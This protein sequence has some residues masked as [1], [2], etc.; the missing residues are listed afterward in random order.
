M[1]PSV[2]E[3]MSTEHEA[4]RP[5]LLSMFATLK[6]LF[7]HC[8]QYGRADLASEVVDALEMCKEDF[9]A[10][11]EQLRSSEAMGECQPPL[12][13]M[14]TSPFAGRA[15]WDAGCGSRAPAASAPLSALG[16]SPHA[17]SAASAAEAEAADADID[18]ELGNAC[19][20]RSSDGARD[21]MLG[22]PDAVRLSSLAP[23]ARASIDASRSAA[24]VAEGGARGG[25]LDRLSSLSVTVA[26]SSPEAAEPSPPPQ[27]VDSP[28]A[29]AAML[30]QL[31]RLDLELL[32]EAAAYFDTPQVGQHTPPAARPR[33]PPLAAWDEP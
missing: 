3:A 11:A 23:H 20:D 28:H 16:R 22:S 33:F 15:G 4:C 19:C 27:S 29:N 13:S 12:S 17:S 21:P 8:E 6:Q 10:M 5:L 7:L 26:I 18:A 24:G 14:S 25:A 31:E 30:S 9:S 32:Q 2:A 1:E